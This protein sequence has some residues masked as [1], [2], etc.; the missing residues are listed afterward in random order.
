M[1][2]DGNMF[3]GITI[4]RYLFAGESMNLSV[5]YIIDS[6]NQAKHNILLS[7]AEKLKMVPND[8]I[9]KYTSGTE[10]FIID[11]PEISGLAKRL[12]ENEQTV[13]DKVVRMISWFKDNITYSNYEIPQYPIDTF[14]KGYGDC[15]DQAILFISMCRSIGIPAFLQIGIIVDSSLNNNQNSW[16]GHF[17]SSQY[18]LGWHGWAM[19]YIPPWGWIPIDLTFT[20]IE[21]GLN[22]LKKAPEYNE[23]IILAMNISKQAYVGDTLDF[24]ERII[25]ST[26]LIHRT[27]KIETMSRN[28]FWVNYG[29]IFLGLSV[30]ICIVLMVRS[31][32]NIY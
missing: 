18:G 8:I 15:D 25:N 3:A 7:R 17:T 16:E 20:K 31:D 14:V 13:L 10:T 24:R 22:I 29:I 23:N 4:Q 30:L 21:E 5:S 2:D 1:D 9:Q 19:V 11:D 32:V 12:T 27:D 28:P 26:L 6:K